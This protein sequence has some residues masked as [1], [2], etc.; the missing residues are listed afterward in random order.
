M[1]IFAFKTGF[2]AKMLL[3]FSQKLLAKIRNIVDFSKR[4]YKKAKLSIQ[5]LSKVEH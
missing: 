1:F 2:L 5:N 3:C 4:S